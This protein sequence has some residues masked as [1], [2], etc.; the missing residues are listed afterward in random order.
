MISHL[1]DSQ[2][3]VEQ[4][5]AILPNVVVVDGSLPGREIFRLYGRLRASAA[6]AAIPIIFTNHVSSASDPPATE[7]PDFYLDPAASIDDIEQLL[8]TF[9]P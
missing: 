4:A 5:G 7:T 2:G 9:F 3:G 8:F 1:L 6:G